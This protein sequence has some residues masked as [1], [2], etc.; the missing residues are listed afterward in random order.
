MPVL[1]SSRGQDLKTTVLYN[2]AEF[3]ADEKPW[4]V[5]PHTSPAK[6]NSERKPIERRVVSTQRVL[7]T[8]E[9]FGEHCTGT[10]SRGVQ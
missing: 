3:K 9:C 5:L 2:S 8:L 1:C 6:P 7:A 4:T 10:S